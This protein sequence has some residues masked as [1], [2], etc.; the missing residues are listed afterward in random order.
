[1]YKLLL[2]HIPSLSTEHGE[3]QKEGK[4][5]M[6]QREREKKIRNAETF[7]FSFLPKSKKVQRDVTKRVTNE[8]KVY[9]RK[10]VIRTFIFLTEKT[11]IK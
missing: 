5:V 1:M 3:K 10:A 11:G 8:I 9:R 4:R 7:Y 6:L 2:M